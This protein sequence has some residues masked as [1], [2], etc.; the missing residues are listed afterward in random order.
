MNTLLSLIL[1][2]SLSFNTTNMMEANDSRHPAF[3]DAI[4][5]AYDAIYTGDNEP[6]KDFIILDLESQYFVDTNYEE[7]Q[8]VIEHFNKYD[9]HV[10]S[11]SLFKLKDIGLVDKLGNILINGDLLMITQLY[12]NKENNLV[13]E[14][15]K[16]HSIVGA[17]I[18]RITLNHSEDQWKIEKNQVLGMLNQ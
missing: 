1:S 14:G 7:R 9:K 8:K 6:R 15:M 16:Y 11:A 10:L 18:Y 2:L 12:S 5:L 4:I 13:I 17:Y 3:I